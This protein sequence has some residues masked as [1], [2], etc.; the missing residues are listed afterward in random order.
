MADYIMDK[1]ER[2][3]GVVSLNQQELHFRDMI[4]KLSL[5]INY[6]E[7]NPYAIAL[8]LKENLKWTRGIAVKHEDS[9]CFKIQ[10]KGS[11]LLNSP[12]YFCIFWQRNNISMRVALNIIQ[13]RFQA[14]LYAN[15]INI[16]LQNQALNK[17]LEQMNNIITVL[18]P[19][20]GQKS[21][22]RIISFLDLCY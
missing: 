9:R 7:I 17:S 19:G 16:R 22:H 21:R 2:I 8:Y 4:D 3:S 18:Y 20:D 12:D 14:E 15:K 5:S 10:R 11:A 6:D 13:A 1:F